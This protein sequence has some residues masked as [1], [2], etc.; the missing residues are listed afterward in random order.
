[1]SLCLAV[2]S[3]TC[4]L[5]GPACH[6]LAGTVKLQ[7]ARPSGNYKNVSRKNKI[8]DCLPCQLKKMS[9]S[10][11]SFTPGGPHLLHCKACCT[12]LKTS[13]GHNHSTGL[14][15]AWC[16]HHVRAYQRKPPTA[17]TRQ[18]LQPRPLLLLCPASTIKQQLL[19]MPALLLQQAV[20]QDPMIGPCPCVCCCCVK[21]KG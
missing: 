2:E 11:A 6:L 14:L 19:S 13:T 20:P 15:Q 18:K 4:A 12:T 21:V 3:K 8:A 16:K 10:W 7:P 1:M 9:L 5:V 17:D